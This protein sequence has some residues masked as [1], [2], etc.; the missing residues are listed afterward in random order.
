MNIKNKI[1]VEEEK[2]KK[3]CEINFNGLNF[4]FKS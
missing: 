3:L 2:E 1:Q 4:R